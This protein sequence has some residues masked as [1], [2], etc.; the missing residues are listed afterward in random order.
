MN[1][2][3]FLQFVA[4][5][6]FVGPLVPAAL[7]APAPPVRWK[8]CIDPG[9]ALTTMLVIETV[10]VQNSAGEPMEAS[11]IRPVTIV[12]KWPKA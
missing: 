3:S 11:I 1:R 10:T 12:N 8:C 4:A 5:L 7:K 2:R 6:P 9:V